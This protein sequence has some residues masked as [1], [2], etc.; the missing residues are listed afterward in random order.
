MYFLI[1]FLFIVKGKKMLHWRFLIS[2]CL[3]VFSTVSCYFLPKQKVLPTTQTS[4]SDKSV[5]YVPVPLTKLSS[6]QSPCLDVDIEGK[7]ISM[8]LDLGFRGDLTLTGHYIDQVSSK[9]FLLTKNM[10]GIR[11]KEYPTNIYRIPEIKIGAMTFIQPKLQ[12]NSE[13][14]IEDSVFVKDGSKPSAREP[15]R[16]GWELFYNVNLLVD[17]KNSTIAFCDGLDTLKKQ[18]YLVET[19]TQAPLLIERGL[20]EFEAQTNEGTLRCMLDTGATFN[21]LNR[22][23]N[24]EKPIAQAIWEPEN[25][26]EYSSFKIGETNF[27][28]VSFHRV[29]IKMP[30]R[31]DA[32]LGMEFFQDH[33]IFLDFAGGY[34]YFSDIHWMTTK[35]LKQATNPKTPQ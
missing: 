18:G 25:V 2:V 11:G 28:P 31:I 26:L 32:I 23:I 19:F 12:K 4:Q 21:M 14:F 20:V 22:G 10:Y 29:P 30:L 7:V 24:G 1:R 15:G 16:L 5:F 35:D 34:V 33:L 9:T 27:A 13:E 17:I 6:I 8:E 3:L